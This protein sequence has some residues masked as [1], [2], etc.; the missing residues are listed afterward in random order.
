MKSKKWSSPILA[1]LW[2]EWRQQWW[3]GLALV[4]MLIL[5]FFG[6]LLAFDKQLASATLIWLAGISV[7]VMGSHAFTGEQ[8]DRSTEFLMLAPVRASTVFWLKSATVLTL[9]FG[10]AFL[11]LVIS[12]IVVGEPIRVDDMRE[13]AVILTSCAL[14]MVAVAL[15][16]AIVSIVARRTISCI[17]VSLLVIPALWGLSMVSIIWSE[18]WG[19][20]TQSQVVTALILH[21]VFLFLLIVVGARWLWCWAQIAVTT[22]A[23]VLRVALLA[24]IYCA[25]T[26]GG[27]M[28]DYIRVTCFTVPQKLFRGQ[29]TLRNQVS[30]DEQY[31][32]LRITN[33]LWGNRERIAV[34]N[35]ESGRGQWPSRFRMSIVNSWL[36]CWSPSSNRLLFHEYNELLTPLKNKQKNGYE[37][38]ILTQRIFA[39]STGER[40]S[41]A[42]IFPALNNDNSDIPYAL[43]WWDDQTLYMYTKHDVVFGN[44]DTGSIWRCKLSEDIA[45][46]SNGRNLS[47]PRF[48]TERGVYRTFREYEDADEISS[49]YYFL[50]FAPDLE[51]CEVLKVDL[52]EGLAFATVP[53]ISKDGRWAYIRA[54]SKAKKAYSQYLCDLTTGKITNLVFPKSNLNDEANER[55]IF[56]SFFRGNN[57][58]LILSSSESIY[59]YNPKTGE[60]IH[61]EMPKLDEYSWSQGRTRLSPSG[62]YLFTRINIDSLKL[63]PEEK[64]VW[65]KRK[66]HRT[67]VMDL[68]TDSYWQPSA[69][70]NLNW[71]N[72]E[73]LIYHDWM[74]RSI[75]VVNRDGT[76]KRKLLPKNEK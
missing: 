19:A 39:P 30:F 60:M 26:V 9:L 33:G 63:K 4:C 1:L 29:V 54:G 64:R 15:V 37:D 56:K 8:D 59:Q 23:R 62:R 14:L 75:M 43:G 38:S 61:R 20:N 41:L 18:W 47:L 36:K 35:L 44:V 76:G 5:V 57:N 3:V 7:V 42:E 49:Q 31:I 71:L 27:V 17:I 69:N 2:K 12:M 65:R 53:V 45:A 21:S 73:Q 50:R 68:D 55:V 13:G 28:A 67:L 32:T 46:Q 52:A 34:I 11:V 25:V 6:T 58:I 40:Q 70:G 48:C 51:E 74:E 72:E 10:G 16:P 24:L 66:Q 22:R